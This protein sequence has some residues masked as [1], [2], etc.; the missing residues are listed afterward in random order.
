[1]KNINTKRLILK[2]INTLDE[3]LL[4]LSLSDFLTQ[5]AL[6]VKKSDANISELENNIVNTYKDVYLKLNHD[7]KYC[8]QTFEVLHITNVKIDS[9]TTDYERTFLL[10]GELITFSDN[11]LDKRH[12]TANNREVNKTISELEQYIRITKEE[13]N[14]YKLQYETINTLITNIIIEKQ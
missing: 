6:D 9:F 7:K 8:G 14:N 11:S 4:D 10:F 13:Y 3:S 1:M 5:I 2:K 12:L